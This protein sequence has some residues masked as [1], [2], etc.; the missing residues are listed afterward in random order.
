[1]TATGYIF[2]LGS[3]LCNGSFASLSKCSTEDL[4][5][6]YFNSCLSLG[7]VISC[8]AFAFA[9]FTKLSDVALFDPLAAGAGC[10]LVLANYF[11]FLAIPRAGLAL[12]QGVWGGIA[13]VISFIWGVYGPQPIGKNPKSI[14]GSYTGIFFILCGIIGI[15]QN[16]AFTYWMCKKIGKNNIFDVLDDDTKKNLLENDSFGRVEIAENLENGE[17]DS[18]IKIIQKRKS[19]VT[20]GLL[21]ATCTGLFGGS[22]LVPLELSAV[23]GLKALPSFG[24]GVFLSSLFVT[25]IFAVFDKNGNKFPKT[26]RN[27][28]PGIL[29]GF[30]FNIGNTFSIL[31]IPEIG[32]AVAQPIMQCALFVS[33]LWGIFLFHEITET[34][35]ILMFFVFGVV[36]IMGALVLAIYG[37]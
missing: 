36:L 13:L 29:S 27:I 31:A 24:H 21:Y 3:A 9:N 12:S 1:M 4:S 15:A 7:V 20:I 26:I 14:V 8:W 34:S 35:R 37:P 6:V 33:G 17:N 18:S 10:L 23:R 30:V 16:E 25:I 19:D 32:F 28:V 2:A 11:A 5:P 22:M